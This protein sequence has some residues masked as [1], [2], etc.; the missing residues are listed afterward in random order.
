MQKKKIIIYSLILTIIPFILLGFLFFFLKE[1]FTHKT[2]DKKAKII[3]VGVS[4]QVDEKAAPGLRYLQNKQFIRTRYI[5]QLSKACKNK[6]V[7]FLMVPI[8]ENQ[9]DKIANI[10][11]GMIF[12]G[13]DDMNAKFFSQKQHPKA[14]KEIEPENRTMFD[15]KLMKKLMKQNKPIMAVCLGM[16]ELNV[17]FGGDIIQDI[18]STLPSSTIKHKGISTL[19]KAHLINISE[20][21][22]LHKITNR[23]TMFV[24]S[25]HH[26]S[27]N[28][29]ADNFVATA[30]APDGIIEAMECK[31]CN[32]FVLGLQWHPEY[33][34]DK[35]NIKIIQ[36]FCDAV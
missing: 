9:I 35:E 26:Q 4:Y 19:K 25:N 13:G 10:V 24:N 21:S 6:N 5:N 27:I 18:E 2:F 22:L 28:K 30:I 1:N 36:A 29:V 7:V 3:G 34:I 17:A 20:N 8:E 23:Q 31:N 16:Q 33:L 14:S 12:T 15:I 32:N 11:D